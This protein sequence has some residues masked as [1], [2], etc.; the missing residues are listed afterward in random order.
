MKSIERR[1]IHEICP[2]YN[3][4]TQSQDAEPNRNVRVYATK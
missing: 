4:E 3:L 1:F 2:Y